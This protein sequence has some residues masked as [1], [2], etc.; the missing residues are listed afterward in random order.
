MTRDIMTA[1][2]NPALAALRYHVTGAI[3]RG[4]KEAIAGIPALTH[5][6][7]QARL[8]NGTN[9]AAISFHGWCAEPSRAIDHTAAKWLAVGYRYYQQRLRDGVP[10][11]RKVLQS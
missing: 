7:Y 8:G 1:S 10:V 3:E 2:K 6:H 5:A 4:E 11:R 9:G